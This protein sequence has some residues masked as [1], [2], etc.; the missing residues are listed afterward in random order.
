MSSRLLGIFLKDSQKLAVKTRLAKGIGEK[1][2]IKIYNLYVSRLIDGFS[3][4][5]KSFTVQLYFAPKIPKLADFPFPC[6]EQADGDL[7]KKMSAFFHHSIKNYSQ[8]MLIGSDAWYS[9]A[10]IESAFDQLNEHFV[11]IQPAMDGGYTLI[12][13]TEYYPKLFHEMPWSQETLLAE[14]LKYLQSDNIDY[15]LLSEKRDLDDV[16]DL[17]FLLE[18]DFELRIEILNIL[19][20]CEVEI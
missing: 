4:N 19:K 15:H 11:V 6:Q 5:G 14:S 12:G 20:E 7:G 2:A 1:A 16:A 17:K 8:V 18:S 9:P 13:M 10:E 3:S